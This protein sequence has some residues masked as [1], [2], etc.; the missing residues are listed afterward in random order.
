[1]FDLSFGVM[2]LFLGFFLLHFTKSLRSVLYWGRQN[3]ACCGGGGLFFWFFFAVFGLFF[4]GVVSLF[5]FFVWF[6]SFFSSTDW[7]WVTKLRLALRKEKEKPNV[8]VDIFFSFFLPLY[9]VKPTVL[10]LEISL[11][12]TLDGALL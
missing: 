9:E 4:F 1:M 5:F 2:C 3:V 10:T 11:G 12:N 7:S 8:C 6:P